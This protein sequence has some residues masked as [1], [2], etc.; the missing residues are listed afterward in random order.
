[1]NI[2][3][4]SASPRRY[5]LLKSKG[6]DFEVKVYDIDET[7]DS[8]KTPYENV[9][10]L[11]LK[12][13]LVNQEADYGK[14]LIGCDTIVVYDGVIYGKP[15]D[16]QDAY[17]TLRKLSGK[18]HQ[19]MSGVGI[20]YKDSV[21]NFVSVSDVYFKELSDEDIWNY[22]KTGECFGK[23][24]S[25]AIQGIG[26]TLVDHYEGSL[27]NIIGLPIEEV[28]NVLGEIYGMEN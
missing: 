12:K 22:I 10:E 15:T 14:I 24:G 21:Y 23:A 18:K 17:N 8:N 28:K 4:K 25:Y 27:E 5:D 2:V 9:K 6:Y 13:A 11:G 3:L 16:E 20:V 26:N 19:V 1:M 7:M